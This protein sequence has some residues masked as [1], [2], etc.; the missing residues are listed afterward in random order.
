MAEDFIA[1]TPAEMSDH[2]KDVARGFAAYLDSFQHLSSEL[3]L[4]ALY[5]AR[6]IDREAM[7]ALANELGKDKAAEVIKTVFE[8]HRHTKRSNYENQTTGESETD[9]GDQPVQG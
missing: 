6:E 4:L 7:L 1:R 3:E 9:R 2:D 8:K 5:K